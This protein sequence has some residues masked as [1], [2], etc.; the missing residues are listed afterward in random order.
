MTDPGRVADCAA[1]VLGPVQMREVPDGSCA[2]SPR[3]ALGGE[4]KGAIGPV[5][6][7][8]GMEMHEALASSYIH[9]FTKRLHALDSTLVDLQTWTHIFALE[10]LSSLILSKSNDYASQGHDGRNMSTSDKHWAYFTVI[11]ILPRLVDLT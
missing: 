9:T 11:G 3:S 8:T 5:H 6:S 2:T 7:V 1:S 4:C 10:V